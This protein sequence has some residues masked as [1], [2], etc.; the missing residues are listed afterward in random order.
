VTEAERAICRRRN[1]GWFNLAATAPKDVG[2]ARRDAG[3]RKV[4]GTCLGWARRQDSVR[5]GLEAEEAPCLVF[6]GVVKE[7]RQQLPMEVDVEAQKLLSVSLEGSV[8]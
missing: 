8:G 5:A 6:N 1:L 3:F 4:D 7:V 2:I